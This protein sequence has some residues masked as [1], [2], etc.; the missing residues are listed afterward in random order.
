MLRISGRVHPE[1]RKIHRTIL[2]RYHRHHSEEGLEQSFNSPDAQ[3]E[4]Y[5]NSQQHEGWRVIASR[6]DDGGFPAIR[7]SGL[8]SGN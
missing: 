4:A 7:W 3:R 1:G 6:Y 8:H 2:Q 5:I